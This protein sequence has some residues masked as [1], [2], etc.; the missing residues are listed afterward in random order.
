VSIRPANLLSLTAGQ[1][2]KVTA[3]YLKECGGNDHFV[4]RGICDHFGGVVALQEGA[5]PRV[6][7]CDRYRLAG[8]L[9]VLLRSVGPGPLP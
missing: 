3:V 6:H 9:V 5:Q 8:G 1:L 2:I 7:P 4:A